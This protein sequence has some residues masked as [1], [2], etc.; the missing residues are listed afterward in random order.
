MNGSGKLDKKANF[1]ND[2]MGMTQERQRE[3]QASLFKMLGQADDPPEEKDDA[4]QQ[5]PS[6]GRRGLSSAP[7]DENVT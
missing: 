7:S 2:N 1:D 4:K 3:I 5:K 6:S